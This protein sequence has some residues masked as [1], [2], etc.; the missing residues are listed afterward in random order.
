MGEAD[1]FLAT[2]FG[3]APHRWASGGFDDLLSLAD[4]DA[5]LSGGGLR[6]PAIRLVRDGEVL[7]PATWT[8]RAR[9]GA[10][11]VDD[12]VHPGR[13]FGLFGD[14]ATIVLQSLHRWWTPLARF[15]RAL[16]G[17]L[18]HAVQANAYLTPP[19]AAGL[20]P[21]HDTHDVFVLQ[22]AGRKHWTVREPMVDAPLARHR[23]DHEE[24]AAQPVLIT[25][26]LRPG[27]CL[28]LPRGFV[29]SAAAQEGVS[30]HITVGV[31]S[32]TLHDLVRRIVD[33][34]ADEPAFRRSLP[35]GYGADLDRAGGVVKEAISELMGWLERLPVD[36]VAHDLVD[37]VARRRAPLLEGQLLELA[38]LGDLDDATVVVRR[39]DV[40]ARLALDGDRARLVLAD[41]SV[42]LPAPVAPA[43]VRLLDGGPHRVADLADLLDEPSRLV[44]VRRLV[45]E[46]VLRTTTHGP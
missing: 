2:C 22:V 32:T 28:Y 12:L 19:G 8:R 39:P 17:A 11:W 21:H 6:R 27:D 15:C 9:T 44:L 1:E 26:A 43:L 40:A 14:G 10:R 4:V 35:A 24:A 20:T 29:H 45:R 16:E 18:G 41:R 5:Q 38:A 7:D 23:S 30:L 13:T 34:T 25:A 36:E 3:V 42:E 33:R 46:A 37:A 31:L